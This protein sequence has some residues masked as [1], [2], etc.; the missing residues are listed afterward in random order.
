MILENQE[1]LKQQELETIESTLKNT[2]ELYQNTLFIME[3]QE[4]NVITNQNNFDRT[5]E[6]YKLGQVTSIEFRQAQINL[7]NTQTALNNAKY[8]AKLIELEL[9]QLSGEILNVTF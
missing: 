4:Q 8:D 7:L 6:R 5:Q 2:F 9:L 1:I 3:A